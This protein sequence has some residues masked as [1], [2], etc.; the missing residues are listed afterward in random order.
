MA[1]SHGVVEPL[2]LRSLSRAI[3]DFRSDVTLCLDD[4]GRRREATL[5]GIYP[6][7][8]G[9]P[10]F[11]ERVGSRFPYVVGEMARGITTV[12]MVENAVGAGFAAFYGSAGLPQPEVLDALRRLR[13]G[14]G[15]AAPWGAN[16][17]HSPQRPEL[18]RDIAALFIAEGLRNVSASAYMALSPHVV[19]LSASGLSRGPDGRVARTARVFA[20]VSRPEVAAA[21]LTPPPADMLRELVS[22]GLLT[23]AQADLQ[24]TRPVASFLTAEADSGGHT[25][26]QALTAL[27]PSIIAMRDRMAEKFGWDDAVVVGAAGGLGEPTSLCAAFAMGAS[28]VVTGSVN[29]A[30]V[31]S[32]VCAEARAMLAAARL[33][34]FALAPAADM[35]EIGAKVQ[36]L[37]RGTLFAANA[38]RLHDLYRRYSGLDALPERDR[39]WLETR[40]L[41]ESVEDA[42]TAVRT[43]YEATRPQ[44]AAAAREDARLRMALVFRRYLFMASQWPRTGETG[45]RGDFQLWCGPAMAAFN[46][47]SED[48]FL[49]APEARTVAQI[50]WNLLEG[51]ARA[52][53]A[54]QLRAVGVPVPPSA[55]ALKPVALSLGDATAARLAAAP[56]TAVS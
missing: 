49:A 27:L 19:R 8:L 24:R 2:D 18:E 45:R 55:G 48:S 4:N 28:Y 31:E 33:G 56:L 51:A 40:V 32:G 30:A 37:K 41:R 42:W 16:L 38:Q 15:A 5:P 25:D 9:G 12:Q 3:S 22:A 20:K 44:V 7:W 52:T 34:D 43:R 14:L 35:F 13:A 6:E 10:D 39:A 36:V 21:F 54:M 11:V 1:A 53:R 50:G 46:G 29:Q 17:I 26:G 47:W 23:E